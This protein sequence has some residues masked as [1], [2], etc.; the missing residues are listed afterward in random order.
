MKKYFNSSTV[1]QTPQHLWP[2]KKEAK[3]ILEE[4]TEGKVK[5]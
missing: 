1:S 3:R 4:K 5:R 2:G